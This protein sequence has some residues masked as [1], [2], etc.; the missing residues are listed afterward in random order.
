MHGKIYVFGDD[1]VED[2][3]C[4]SE[5]YDPEKDLWSPIKPMPGR[6]FDKAETVGEEIFV[7]TYYTDSVGVYHPR[8]D[9]WRVV[10]S[11][12]RGA[13]HCLFE[14]RGKLHS[15]GLGKFHRIEPSE[16]NVYDAEANSWAPVHSFSFK[17]R[18][19]GARRLRFKLSLLNV[20][21]EL[22]LKYS[23]HAW[24]LPY[25]CLAKSNGFGTEK[26]EILWQDVPCTDF[27]LHTDEIT[28]VMF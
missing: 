22:L 14:A 5:V 26:N 21:D 16:I 11:F 19:N 4:S 28:P 8:K 20:G 18:S 3:T 13:T 6:F 24:R 15:I 1:D 17:E 23:A 2:K 27:L 25:V 9:E 10:T 12:G 7:Y